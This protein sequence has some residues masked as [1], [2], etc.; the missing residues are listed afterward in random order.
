MIHLVGRATDAVFS[1]LGPATAALADAGVAQ[2][3]VLFD[4]PRDAHLF[5]RFHHSVEL[6]LMP[7]DR[8]PMRRWRQALATFRASLDRGPV[9]AVHLH[10]LLPCLFGARAASASGP[11]V[12][13][14]FS[15][16]GSKL[17]G[18]QRAA[19]TVLLWL[20]RPLGGPW[21]QQA[22]A[23]V[24]ADARRLTAVTRQ[25]V[26]L[27]E[28]P[29]SAAF[30]QAERAEAERPLVVTGSRTQDPASAE[31]FAR[32]A[33]LLGDGERGLDFHWIG[34]VDPESAA[35]L[36]AAEVSVFDETS[37]TGRAH[38]LAAGWVFLAPGGGLGFPVFLAEAMAAGLPCVAIDT[39][40][41]RDLIRDGDTGYL[42]GTEEDALDRIAQ[43]VDSAPQRH[44][45]GASARAEAQRRFSD[46]K[47]RG[48]LLSLYRRVL[49][50]GNPSVEP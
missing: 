37:D 11:E 3:V 40:Y 6:L 2:T 43:L 20:F 45:F 29:V 39:P 14:F 26:E 48:S 9:R 31:L 32:M 28:S 12:P 47:F 7:F 16:H 42:C 13:V 22:I 24:G 19:G 38:R 46:V 30:F 23:S 36:K 21:R 17:L 4:D 33:V 1:F 49:P 25:S 35:R 10:G 27:L 15:P 8:S 18:P 5:P 50:G 34:T 41:H 44:Q